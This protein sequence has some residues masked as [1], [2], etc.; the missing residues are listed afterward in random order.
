MCIRDRLIGLLLMVY[1]AGSFFFATHFLP[2]TTLSQR[3]ISLKTPSEVGDLI[4]A[5]LA[6]YEVTVSG[7]GFSTKISAARAGAVSYTHLA[8][9][10]GFIY[11]LKP[12]SKCL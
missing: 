11:T 4:E 1:L 2:G 5:D 9:K 7:H 6:N 8:S 12:D 10:S 3:D